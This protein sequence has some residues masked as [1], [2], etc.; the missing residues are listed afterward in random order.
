MGLSCAPK[1]EDL[2]LGYMAL[3]TAA[4]LGMGL[5]CGFEMLLLI[6][7]TFRRRS[8]LYYW[9]LVLAATSE[10]VVNI[11]SILYYWTFRNSCPGIVAILSIPGTLGYVLFE[12]LI[13]YSRLRLVQTTN[14]VMRFLL[15]IICLEV[16]LVEV[17]LAI[18]LLGSTVRPVSFFTPLYHTMWQAEAIVYTVVD[19]ILSLTYIIQ[20]RRFWG[21]DSSPEIRSILRDI[22][23]MTIFVVG[24]D[25]TNA[26]LVFIVPV[27]PIMY[28]LQ[29][30]PTLCC[31]P[32]GGIR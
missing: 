24:F 14:K 5:L 12:Y 17:P 30:C 9:S 10:L 27:F 21:K 6:W 7:Y 28:G 25:I 2:V 19:I 4:F 1:G 26:V 29:V 8:G 3:A 20:I 23:V 22:I 13:L 11:S 31:S 18:I 15:A 32:S 16:L